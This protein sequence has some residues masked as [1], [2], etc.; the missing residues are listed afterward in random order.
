MWYVRVSELKKLLTDL[1]RELRR[2]MVGIGSRDY[3]FS[4]INN[5]FIKCGRYKI[6]LHSNQFFI[7]KKIYACYDFC[8]LDEYVRNYCRS[9][10]ECVPNKINL[11]LTLDYMFNPIKVIFIFN[12][13]GELGIKLTDE[14]ALLDWNLT[15]YSPGHSL[16]HTSIYELS[17]NDEIEDKFREAA[18]EYVRRAGAYAII[19][20]PEG[21]LKAIFEA[22]VKLVKT[23]KE[24][25]KVT[26]F[27]K[28]LHDLYP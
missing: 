16:S 27:C 20:D 28:S 25:V 9:G 5:I 13:I 11:G 3:I 1:G 4:Y 22:G 2:N 8:V 23:L 10:W 6:V 18:E 19:E 15:Y 21:T 14:G 26:P 7:Y 17:D 24:G 12:K